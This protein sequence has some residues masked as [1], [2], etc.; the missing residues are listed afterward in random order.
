MGPKLQRRSRPRAF[1]VK[2]LNLSKMVRKIAYRAEPY[3]WDTVVPLDHIIDHK[4]E[5]AGLPHAPRVDDYQKGREELKR[6][7][8]SLGFEWKCASRASA[9]EQRVNRI[10]QRLKRHDEEEVY[11]KEPPQQGVTGQ[12]HQR[13]AGDHFLSNKALIDRTKVFKLARRAPKGAHLHIHFNAC[14]Q[15]NVLLQIASEMD[16]MY[17]TSDVPLHTTD[18]E[19]PKRSTRCRIQFSIIDIK[20]SKGNLFESGYKDRAPMKFKEFIKEFPR[21]YRGADALEWLQEKLVFREEEAHDLPQTVS[22]A[23]EEFNAR[24]QMMKGLF[25][26][27]RAYREYTRR[28]LEDFVSD[29]IQYAEIRPN[30]MDTNQVWTD[31][32][33]RKIDN[34]GIMEMI[35]QEVERF[36]REKKGSDTY[37]AGLKVIYC[38][39]RSYPREKVANGLAECLR[40]KKRWPG[41]IAGFDLVG[42][43]GKGRPLSTFVPEFLQFQKDCA[44]AGVGEIPFLFHCGETLESGSETDDNL[45]DALLLGSRRIGHGFSLSRHPYLMERMKKAGVCVE[46]CPI[47]NEVLGLTPRVGGHAMY[48]MLANNV[49]CTVSSDNGTLFNST[50]SHDFYQAMIGKSDMTLFGWKQLIEWSLEHACMSPAEHQDVRRAWEVRWERFVDE[51]LEEFGAFDSDFDDKGN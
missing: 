6:R 49:H 48:S 18:E 15:P 46:L 28:F 40:F 29:N 4:L 27:E 32:G 31:D 45:L 22:G 19:H 2:F 35:I 34:V 41:W 51:T 17:I 3:D 12:S 39:P 38:C 24:T 30:F 10:L 20:A 23:W 9:K 1:N 14:L 26:Y 33:T 11:A 25:N 7:E 5:T 42:E 47:S 36:Q 50:L 8:A 21:H 16:Q 13:F 37:F 43:E 44:A